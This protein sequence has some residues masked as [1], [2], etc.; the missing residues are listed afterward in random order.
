MKNEMNEE[1]GNPAWRLSGAGEGPTEEYVSCVDY[2]K[3]SEWISETQVGGQKTSL[4]IKCFRCKT[5]V[6]DEDIIRHYEECIRKLGEGRGSLDSSFHHEINKRLLKIL[7]R[8]QDLP[9]PNKITCGYENDYEWRVDKMTSEEVSAELT[10][11]EKIRGRVADEPD[12]KDD[13]TIDAIV[14]FAKK[15]FDFELLEHHKTGLRHILHSS[16]FIF[17]GKKVDLIVHDEIE[18]ID[19]AEIGQQKK[20]EEDGWGDR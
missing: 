18:E 8:F 9:Y 3:R 4:G 11:I 7:L 2:M 19:L 14:A 13:E 12:E 20:D 1:H 10:K 16:P 6:K 15:Y 17:K 5:F